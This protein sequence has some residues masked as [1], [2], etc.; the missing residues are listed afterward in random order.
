MEE[1][2]IRRVSH[3]YHYFLVR[4]ATACDVHRSAKR[5]MGI[6]RICEVLVTE[7]EYGF[8]VKA[9]ATHGAH[10]TAARIGRVVGGGVSAV[11]G[12]YMYVR[13]TNTGRGRVRKSQLR[14]RASGSS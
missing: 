7:G 8:V 11:T 12:H 13:R 2:K 5:M 10:Y 4:P 6:E 14:P 3:G 9:R 1:G